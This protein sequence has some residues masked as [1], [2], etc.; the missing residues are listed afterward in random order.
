MTE[1]IFSFVECRAVTGCLNLCPSAGL[2]LGA[3]RN[4]K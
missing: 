2:M 3:R 1:G 4:Y